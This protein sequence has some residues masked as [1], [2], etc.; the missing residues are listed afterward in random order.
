MV[1]VPCFASIFPR[2]CSARR[3]RY[4]TV[5]QLEDNSGGKVDDDRQQCGLVVGL[6]V[7]RF[8]VVYGIG[9]TIVL[10]VRGTSVD[11]PTAPNKTDHVELFLLLFMVFTEFF[12]C[13]VC[14]RSIA[15]VYKRRAYALQHPSGLEPTAP[16]YNKVMLEKRRGKE[17]HQLYGLNFQVSVNGDEF[18]MV[19]SVQPGSLLDQWNNHSIERS[20]EQLMEEAWGDSVDVP[21]SHVEVREAAIPDASSCKIHLGDKIVAV[22]HVSADI[23][24][25]QAEL[26]QPKVTLWVLRE[27]DASFSDQ[28]FPE[29][30]GSLDTTTPVS[31]PTSVTPPV[32]IGGSES[33]GA[34]ESG[35]SNGEAKGPYFACICLEDEVPLMPVQWTLCSLLLGWITLLPVLF[36]HPH[37]ERPRQQIFRQYLLKSSILVTLIWLIFL[38]LGLVGEIFN[39]QLISPFLHM[40]VCQMVLPAI[41]VR[42]IFKM[43]KV[44]EQLV[45]HARETRRAEAKSSDTMPMCAEDPSPVFLKELIVMNPLALSL[46]GVYVSIP[47][48]VYSFLNP[49]ATERGKMVQGHLHVLYIPLAFLQGIIICSVYDADFNN[50]IEYYSACLLC[51]FS[52][53]SL[54]MWSLFA[55]FTWRHNGH[56]VELVKRQ[57]RER[58]DAFLSEMS[59]GRDCQGTPCVESRESTNQDWQVIH[60]A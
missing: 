24:S 11:L 21:S 12:L 32:R 57:R 28:E 8:S 20:T 19:E 1:R 46:I 58:A 42:C 6:W 31:S 51:I 37:E 3:N 10:T 30:Q 14:A 44:D 5:T 60:S 4:S 47:I 40:I 25:M 13:G 54:M 39:F 38:I 18:L 41:L 49:L 56:D 43:Q 34:S 16:Y 52:I 45:L 48:L 55:V 2:I 35:D 33:D 9:A 7:L 27:D 29:I 59:P 23:G 26:L 17:K 22:N 53:P 36:M 15:T 50:L